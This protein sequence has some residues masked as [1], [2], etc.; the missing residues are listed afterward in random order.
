MMIKFFRY[1]RIKLQIGINILY[2][3][4]S[5]TRSK[6]TVTLYQMQFI[7]SQQDYL[8]INPQHKKGQTA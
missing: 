2:M 6:G 4:R 3:R 7:Q 5:H 1:F 8:K